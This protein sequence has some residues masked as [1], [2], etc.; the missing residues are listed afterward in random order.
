M[1]PKP[2]ARARMTV[3]AVA[4]IVLAVIAGSVRAAARATPTLVID[5]SFV[6]T[7]LDPEAAHTPTALIVQKA[8][9]DTL[10]TSDGLGSKPR[11]WLATSYTAAPNS[12]TFTFKIRK[13]VRF[14][15]GSRLTSADVVFSLRRLV[16]LRS[17]VSSFFAGV[18]V[19]A[20]NATTV[21]LRS[22]SSNPAIPTLLTIPTFGIVNSKLVQAN[23]GSDA[24][25][26]ASKDHAGPF[27]NTQTAGSGPYV[28]S[29]YTTNSTVVLKANP[30][31]WGPKPH[32][33][34]VVIRNMLAPTQLLNVQRG[35]NEVAIDLSGAQAATLKSKQKIQ[36]HISP[37][38]N[39]FFLA[40]NQDSNVSAAAA[41][42]HIRAAIRYGIDYSQLL[43]VAG[44][45]AAQAAGVIPSIVSG[46]LPRS[47]APKTNLAKARA[48][49]AASGISQPSITIAYPS[50]LTVNGLPFGPLAEL[51]SA[52]LSAI[53]IKVKLQGI[54]TTTFLSLYGAGKLEAGQVY[55]VINFPDPADLRKFL[56]GGSYAVRVKW[57]KGDD[58]AIMRAYQVAAASRVRANR[59]KRFQ[60]IQR[61]LNASGPWIPL[62]QPSQAIVGSKNLTNLALTPSWTVNV[63]AIGSS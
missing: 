42:S 5:T 9:Y 48:E 25:D 44:P 27:F 49:V 12:K 22:S 18:T 54:P 13:G 15:D 20:P 43:K 55:W 23:G 14:A 51:V 28:L 16:N 56:P 33:K 58:Q 63:A 61:T 41:N 8:A 59:A 17:P 35:S 1:Y 46:A 32:F 2:S 62:F 21:V 24:V 10:L 30:R 57:K 7:S 29:S 40:L 36:V 53:G 34:T 60:A 11:P 6:I 4:V 3:G 38:S 39:V 26:A 52:Q 47:E 37:S 50:D 19:A 31:Y 45:G